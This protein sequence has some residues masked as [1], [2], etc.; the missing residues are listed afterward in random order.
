MLVFY[1]GYVVMELPSNIFIKRFGAAN[2]LAGL[3][4]SW[5]VVTLG[6]GFSKNWVT[7]TVLRVLLG[8][9]EAVSSIL[10]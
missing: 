3:A 5:G 10:R 8:T 4:I 6:I 1:I 9:L 7:L 2:W